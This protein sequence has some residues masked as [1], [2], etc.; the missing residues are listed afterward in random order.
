MRNKPTIIVFIGLFLVI[1]IYVM[2]SVLTGSGSNIGALAKYVAVGSL[3]V[4]IIYRKPAFYL[5]VVY[6]AISDLLKRLL[7]VEGEFS[8]LDIT[9]ILMMSPLLMLGIFLGVSVD[10][11]AKRALTRELKIALIVG[12][13]LGGYNMASAS[14][15]GDSSIL[16]LLQIGANSVSYYYLPFCALYVFKGQRDYIDLIKFATFIF[17]PVALFAMWQAIVGYS[18]FEIA[19]LLSGF[20]SIGNLN[21]IHATRPFSTVSSPGACAYTCGTL[22]MVCFFFANHKN[23]L[24][25]DGSLIP[26]RQT[27]ISILFFLILLGGMF[28]TKNRTQMLVTLAIIPY[29]YLLSSYKK[30]IIAYASVFC[31]AAFLILTSGYILDNNLI[32]SYQ[33]NIVPTLTKIT[34][35]DGRYFTLATMNIR[36]EGWDA[37]MSNPEFWKPFGNSQLIEEASTMSMMEARGAGIRTHDVISGSLLKFGY[38]PILIVAPVA[39]FIL[40]KMHKFIARIPSD[41]FESKAIRIGL[42]GLFAGYMGTL[43]GGALGAF[44]NPVIQNLLFTLVLMSLLRVKQLRTQQI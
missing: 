16:G 33:N 26:W 39:I 30:T 22:A 5:L 7:V 21:D 12:T 32:E 42:L 14:I 41:S 6:A 17:V 29:F 23:R 19:Y 35:L 43:A 38:V 31:F 2:S 36:F 37:V 13:L 20:T 4:G 34:G 18:E 24:S 10:I 3:F 15:G 25:L 44:P 27:S 40:L 8:Q 11:I 9:Y 1:A 28:V